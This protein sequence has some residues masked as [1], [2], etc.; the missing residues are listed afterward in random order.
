MNSVY[1]LGN[2]LKIPIIAL[3]T[4]QLGNIHNSVKCAYDLGVRFIDTSEM[5][6]NEKELGTALQKNNLNDVFI[7]TKLWQSHMSHDSAL[8]AFETS[9]KNLTNKTKPIDS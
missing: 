9:W 6:G 7:Q 1:T 5:Y 8:S 2:G 3:G 4:Y